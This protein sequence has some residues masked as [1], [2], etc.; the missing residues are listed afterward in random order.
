MV[1]AA[2]GRHAHGMTS[3]PPPPPAAPPPPL[4]P[5]FDPPAWQSPPPY[6]PPAR[7]QLRRS[8]TDKIL[9]G[10]NGGLADYTGIDALLW[11]VGFVAL[12]LAGGAGVV[13]YLLLWLLMPAGPPAGADA[14]SSRRERAPLGPRSP[15]PGI[16]IAVLLILMGAMAMFSTFTPWEI[17]PRGYFGM[18]LLVVG[19]GLVAAAFATGR[20][21]RAGLIALGVVLSL[22]LAAA[23]S[24]PWEGA[25][26][27]AGDRTYRPGTAAAVQDAYRGDVG[28]LTLDLTAI[29]VGAEGPISTRVQHGAGDVRVLVPLDA[30]VQL[31]VDSGLG[32][33]DAFGEGNTD[34]YF[35]GRGAGPTVDDGV[36]DL[37]LIIHNGLGDVEV[38]R[39]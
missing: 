17:H 34:G 23:A 12:T 26:S 1:L 32:S 24:E 35:A 4:P 30:D 3:A 31:T 29:D 39:G 37:N 33:V 2:G 5:S 22:G 8:R 16:T 9:G 6:Q 19:I 21:A 27:G 10:V 7:A 14:P 25:G 18:A 11:R 28:D 13:V 36:P 15:V 38:S 20:T